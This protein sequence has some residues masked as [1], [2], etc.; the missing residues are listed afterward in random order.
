V[1]V[2]N[3]E[4]RFAANP[5]N[6]FS[7]VGGAFYQK[8]EIYN[9]VGVWLGD[10]TV[11]H[12]SI[13]ESRNNPANSLFTDSRDESETEAWGVFFSSSYDLSDDLVLTAAVRYDKVEI[14]TV[15]VGAEETLNG[16]AQTF[17]K[18]LDPSAQASAGFDEWQP[19]LNLAYNLTEDIMLYADIARGFRAGVPNPFTTY[20]GGLPRF[21]E[22][23]VA[24]TLELG[25]KSMLMGNRLS[26]NIALFKTDIENRH[27]YFYGAS[28]QSMDTY[29]E[30]EVQGLEIDTV[31]ML[32]ESLRLNASYGVMSAE[33]ASDERSVYN[34]FS[35]GE[36]AVQVNNKGNVLPDTPKSTFNLALTYEAPLYGD[37]D[38]FGRIGYRYV[39]KLY[40]DT[41]NNISTDGSKQYLDLRLGL[42]SEDW[43][44]VGFVNN[45]TDERSFSNYAYSGGQGNYLPNTP[46]TYGFEATYRF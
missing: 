22:P 12:K 2:F 23:E 45:A 15:Y 11:G 40:F 9:Q 14:D 34:D 10:F 44:L 28:L 37:M 17:A 6:G 31:M 21:I 7:W 19:K 39:S 1:D 30:A 4:V 18:S 16:G 13:D 25:L 41:E 42:K 26:L 36:P 27:H 35:T 5:V 46:K 3:Q 8:R 20:L 43:D 29:K 38:L 32:T 33:I 24:D